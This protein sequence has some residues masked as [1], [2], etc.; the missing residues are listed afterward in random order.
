MEQSSVQIKFGERLLSFRSEY[1][2][3]PSPV[4]IPKY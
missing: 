1:S 4:Q 3:F 2:I